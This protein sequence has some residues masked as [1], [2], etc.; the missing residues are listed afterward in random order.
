MESFSSLQ[1]RVYSLGAGGLSGGNVFWRGVV[2][3]DAMQWRP[4][5]CSPPLHG[6]IWGDDITIMPSQMEVASQHCDTV[7]N[8]TKD[9][10]ATV[11]IERIF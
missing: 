5:S 6:M 10:L 4:L 11:K 8:K 1:C 9:I 2:L 3:E 7:T